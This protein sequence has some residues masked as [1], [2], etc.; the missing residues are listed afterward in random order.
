[1]SQTWIGDLNVNEM[2]CDIL[3]GWGFAEIAPVAS[4]SMPFVTVN[5]YG[6][7]HDRDRIRIST[8]R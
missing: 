8:Q 4:V 7:E 5:S 1:M 6:G 2:R 3:H